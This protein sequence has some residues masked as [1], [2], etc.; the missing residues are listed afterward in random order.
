MIAGG[1]HNGNGEALADR[2]AD[3]LR[4]IEEVARRRLRGEYVPDEQVT[5]DHPDLAPAL[6]VQLRKLGLIERARQMAE[7]AGPTRSHPLDRPI[8]ERDTEAE[9]YRPRV[10]GYQVKGEVQ[11]GG[12]ATVY[13]AVQEATGMR[14]A[15]KVLP[16]GILT[17][18]LR[19][20]RF[21]REAQILVR[22]RHPNVVGIID[23]GRTED[24]SFYLVMPYIEGRPL[25]QYAA[26]L[27]N[28]RSG[29]EPFPNR[30]ARVFAKI[31]SAMEEAHGLGTVHRDLK[32]ANIRVDARGEPHVL[33]FGLAR[34][35]APESGAGSKAE[36]AMSPSARQL[37]VSGQVLGS[38]P[39][40]SPEQVSGASKEADHRSDVY[41]LGVCLHQCLTGSMPYPVDGPIPEVIRH[42]LSTPPSSPRSSLT[43]YFRS[44][45]LESI[46]AKALQK[47]P[48]KR[49]RTAGELAKD[50]LALADGRRVLAYEA[51]RDTLLGRRRM[52]RRVVVAAAVVGACLAGGGV[53]LW[54]QTKTRWGDRPKPPLNVFHLP[55]T[56]NTIGMMLVRIPPGE[57]VMGTSDESTPM[58]GTDERPHQVKITRPFWIGTTE[59]TRGQYRRLMGGLPAGDDEG[60]STDHVPV[61]H[62]SWEDANAFCR[63]LSD[64]EDGGITYRLPT[65]AEWEY[66][67]RAG[68]QSHFPGRGDVEEMA[69]HQGNSGGS[70]HRVGDK[71]PNHW[72]LFDMAGNVAEWCE[73][74]YT[75]VY[76]GDFLDPLVR[77]EGP[78]VVRGGGFDRPPAACRS[79]ARS[80]KEREYR[81]KGIGFRVVMVDPPKKPPASTAASRPSPDR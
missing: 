65:E 43:G 38:L 60:S 40:A 15:I 45:E 63:R 33:D 69:W 48:D 55:S 58:R 7:R 62:V 16:G 30:L 14:V 26:E 81:S 2:G 21:E 44:P 39:W 36:G 75:T 25:D 68:T 70:P 56:T 61:R 8:F 78:A 50:L 41:S 10:P 22:L 19:R 27:R 28:D 9:R 76:P 37:T 77:G 29:E 3:V 47:E 32:P 42:I 73:D 71:S 34:V 54:R 12:Q 17:G 4:V 46:V 57:F 64:L 35:L 74:T 79:A 49:Y 5:A 13:E 23:K 24:G 80:W 67:C 18:S 20:E 51:A 31:A 59:V 72:G 53:W 52:L 1:Q 66:A 6:T 11:S